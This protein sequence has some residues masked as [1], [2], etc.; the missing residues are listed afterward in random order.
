MD[1]LG[2]ATRQLLREC[3]RGKLVL[4]RHL[5][6]PPLELGEMG[7]RQQCPANGR[8]VVDASM[9]S[10]QVSTCTASMASMASVASV[11]SMASEASVAS[12]ASEASVASVARVTSRASEAGAASAG[13]KR[14][15]DGGTEG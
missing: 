15:W 14:W 2:A 11:A 6:E 7:G 10:W 13:R 3:L 12:M 1:L 5:H 9:A 8:Q 4:H